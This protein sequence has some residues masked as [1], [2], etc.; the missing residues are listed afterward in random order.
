MTIE[1]VLNTPISTTFQN[2]LTASQK[3]VTSRQILVV[4]G[5]LLAFQEIRKHVNKKMHFTFGLDGHLQMSLVFLWNCVVLVVR[6]VGA[7]TNND[8]SLTLAPIT[9]NSKFD[10]S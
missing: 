7:I 5:T 6:S 10:T 1:L 8:F 9:T 3:F 4:V 2:V